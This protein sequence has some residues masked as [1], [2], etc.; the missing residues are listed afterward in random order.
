[1]C[2]SRTAELHARFQPGPCAPTEESMAD[3]GALGA[4]SRDGR[5]FFVSIGSEIL[6]SDTLAGGLIRRVDVEL[7]PFEAIFIL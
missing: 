7:P 5:F 2:L 4:V 6:V 1:M 3:L